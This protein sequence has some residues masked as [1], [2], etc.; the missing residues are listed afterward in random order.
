VL[1]AVQ[2]NRPNLNADLEQR[3]L[4]W[5]TGPPNF[6]ADKTETAKTGKP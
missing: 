5:K 4:A 2:K 1:V 3:R 6:D